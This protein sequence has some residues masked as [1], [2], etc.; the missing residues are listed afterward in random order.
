MNWIRVAPYVAGSA[1]IALALADLAGYADALP[2][3]PV[4]LIV[5]SSP[6]WLGFLYWVSVGNDTLAG[7]SWSVP[8]GIASAI[9]FFAVDPR[10]GVPVPLLFF[11]L[12]ALML[13]SERAQRWWYARF[14][15]R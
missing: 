6:G 1:L 8:L 5:G 13:F 9:A 2:G 15:R 4:M 3:T 7:L 11:A 10:L 12:M 14:V